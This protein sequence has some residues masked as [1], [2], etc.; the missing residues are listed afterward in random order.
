MAAGVVVVGEQSSSSLD[1][2][3]G[4]QGPG[5]ASVLFLADAAAAA[6]L[7]AL[8]AVLSLSAAA[9]RRRY[10][11]AALAAT[12]ATNRSLY[13]AL[14]IEQLVVVGFGAVTGVVAGLI[15]I[16]LAG[17]NVPE[18]VTSP[19]SSL[20]RYRPDI[21][22]LGLTLGGAVVLLLAA[23]AAPAAALLRSVNPEQ[24]REAPS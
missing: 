20:L 13:G 12:G 8:A 14:A 3:F 1:D 21:L 22:F 23:A 4:R 5:L 19:T 2:E 17:H 9:R 10:E 11:Y 24:L 15:A 7:A 18:F 16:A 6:V